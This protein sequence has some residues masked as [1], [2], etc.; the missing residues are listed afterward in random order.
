MQASHRISQQP[1][2]IL[3][4]KP[5]RDTSVILELFTRSHG[6]I[7]AVA[8][9]ARQAKSKFNGILQPFTPV[10]ASWS[11]R[12]DL[13]TLTDAE[14]QGLTLALGGQKLMAGFYLNELLLRLLQR[15]D[16]HD[17]LFQAYHET[18][19]RLTLSSDDEPLLR[20]FEYYLLQEIGYGLTLDHDVDS[21]EPIQGNSD[22]CYYIE[23]GPVKIAKPAMEKNSL[24]LKGETLQAL[25]RGELGTAAM[26]KEA[27]HFMRAIIS[28]HLGGKPL[29][30]RE[31]AKQKIL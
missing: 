22:Y 7:A 10:L 1:A 24:C 31:M 12:S 28:H 30:S 3:H 18:L 14:L 16:P 23:R 2:Y 19:T 6:R 8:K 26:L 27:K 5:Y 4:S 25:E 17:E 20:R 29:H 21:G 11:G 15:H 13:M 9:G